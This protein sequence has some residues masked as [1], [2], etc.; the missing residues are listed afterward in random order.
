MSRED[1]DCNV[2]TVT[3]L[4]L[5]LYGG[6]S[7][8]TS[9]YATSLLAF[10]LSNPASATTI[11]SF[12]LTSFE[13][14]SPITQWSSTEDGK[15]LI[16]F[17]A[18]YFKG[19]ANALNAS[20]VNTFLFYPFTQHSVENITE[21]ETFNYVINFANGQSFSGSLISQGPPSYPISFSFNNTFIVSSSSSSCTI[22]PYTSLETANSSQGIYTT[23]A[24]FSC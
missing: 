7:D 13:L 18:P 3:A 24:T 5:T 2:K 11:T 21:G 23:M 22:S 10:A 14:L 20:S 6:T 15:N 8:S 9:S 17:N 16:N 19:Y 4:S 12:T 1:C